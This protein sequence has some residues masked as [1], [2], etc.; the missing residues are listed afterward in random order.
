[1]ARGQPGGVVGRQLQQVERDALRRLRADAGQPAELVDQ[2]L[3]RPGVDAQ[4]AG[5]WP[6]SP[7]RPPRSTPPSRAGLELLH[8]VDGVVEGGEHEVLRASR[9]RRGRPHRARSMTDWK[10]IA[11]VTGRPSTTP[12]PADAFDDGLPRPAPGCRP[13][14]A[15][16]AGLLE[17]GAEV[18]VRPRRRRRRSAGRSA[19]RALDPSG[20]IGSSLASSAHHGSPRQLGARE[21]VGRG[22]RRRSSTAGAGSSVAD[23]DVLVGSGSDVRLGGRVRAGR[24][25]LAGRPRA[26][27]RSG[28][29]KCVGQRRLDLGPLLLALARRWTS[30]GQRERRAAVLGGEEPPGAED[31]LGQAVDQPGQP[32]HRAQAHGRAGVADRWQRRPR[33]RRRP[34]ALGPAVSRWRLSAG[35]R[36]AGGPP[37]GRARRGPRRTGAAA[38][39]RFGAGRR[40][41][42]PASPAAPAG[43][44]RGRRA[45]AAPAPARAARCGRR[46]RR[47][48]RSRS[49]R[50]RRTSATSSA[51]RGLGGLAHVEQR[52]ADRLHAPG[53]TARSPRRSAHA[54]ATRSRSRLGG[55]V[56]GRRPCAAR[57]T[58]RSR[59]SSASASCAGSRPGRHR[60]GHGGEGR[61]VSRS[62]SA[63][64]SSSTRLVVGR[65]PAGGRRSGRAPRAC[66]GPSRR[67]GG[68]RGRRA[69][70]AT[71]R[72]AS[73]IDP[74][75]VLGEH[76]GRQQVELEVLGAAAD[77]V[78]STFCGSVVASTNTT[79][80][81]GSSS[82]FRSAFDA[83]GESMWTSSRMYTFVRPGRAERDPLDEVADVVDPLFDAASSSLDVEG[84]ARPRSPGTTRTR[85]TARRPQVR[86]S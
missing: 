46:A 32:R 3:D 73:S 47:G 84:R 78:G 5:H 61:P 55:V 79:W 17:Q 37:R 64:T 58:S 12:P 63:S 71:S 19:R 23:V 20:T 65:D 51:M 34:A 1:M 75:H 56:D 13:S 36:R 41:A 66:R 31:R 44:R 28:R 81:G 86:R 68:R 40:R 74:A 35:A 27:R 33:G 45:G 18:E 57:N 77:G 11:A 24:R 72:P 52:L 30:F 80:A 10:S 2:V 9:R 50:V 85:R 62:H 38:C 43:S 76:V 53:S 26:R 67:P 69:S 82:V 70:S 42:A 16:S 15:A 48:R 59:P 29:P 22:G 60:L 14:A 54:S 7:P 25:P 8:L 6:R 49:G 83:P 21:G 39:R 4:P